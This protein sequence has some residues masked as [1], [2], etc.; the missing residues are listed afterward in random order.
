MTSLRAR[1]INF[2]LRHSV[3]RGLA[4]SKTPQDVRRV[5]NSAR[6]FPPRGVRFTPATLGGVPGEW[7]EAADA[8]AQGALLYLHGGGY[9]G[10][11]PR[12]HRAITGA[13]ARR[14]LR[15][16]APDYRLA[17]EHVFPAALD[18]ATAA[19]RA[20]RAAAQGPCYVAGDSAG[21]GLT[22][23]LLLNLRDKGLPLPDAAIAF[24]PW[25]DLAITGATMKSNAKRDP[26]LVSDGIETIAAAYL[27]DAD[28]RNPL[29]SPL[30]GDYAGLP[31][32]LFSVGD[33]EILLDDS[34][35]AAERAKAAGVTT[36]ICVERDMPHVFVFANRWTP[37][38]RR[39][40]D[41]A[42]AFLH[43]ASAASA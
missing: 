18:D 28:A 26:L 5:F 42:T 23:A 37:E 41:E 34:V 8:L 17:P 16:F 1:F 9:V 19:W 13:F 38:A 11:S 12:T 6:S 40:M 36:K 10:M 32:I 35:R 25:T 7:V 2:A 33:T 30:Y 31:P 27:G 39:A 22:L 15:V 29:A 14:G 20:L 4:K 21:G 3:K 24:S 43:R